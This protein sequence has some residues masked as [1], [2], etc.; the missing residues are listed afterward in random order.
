LE[1]SWLLYVLNRFE[2][3]LIM[4]LSKTSLLIAFDIEKMYQL[5]RNSGLKYLKL[6]KNADL[7]KFNELAHLS[8]RILLFH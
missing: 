1:T 6:K 5:V 8:F 4:Y 2:N 7:E 3:Q